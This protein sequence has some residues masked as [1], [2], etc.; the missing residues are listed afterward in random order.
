MTQTRAE[1]PITTRDA[2]RLSGLAGPERPERHRARIDDH[3]DSHHSPAQ[4]IGNRGLN[5]RHR[6]RIE[7]HGSEA[8]TKQA[9]CTRRRAWRTGPRLDGSQRGMSAAR[10]QGRSKDGHAGEREPLFAAH[11]AERGD[12]ERAHGRA[13]SAAGQEQAVAAHAGVN[14]PRGVGGDHGFIAHADHAEEGHE[15]ELGEEPAVVS[16]VAQAAQDDA[17]TERF[18]MMGAWSMDEPDREHGDDGGHEAHAVEREAA[19]CSEEREANAGERRAEHARGV[20]QPGVEGDC[21]RQDFG[22]DQLEEEDLAAGQLE[23]DADSRERQDR[24][25][26]ARCA[27]PENRPGRSGRRPAPSG[28]IP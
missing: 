13:D 15:R 2:P 11:S 16:K 23:G 10:G 17:D 14:D 27:R 20:E 28:R 9:E 1:R 19:G 3:P 7:E 25:P 18:A 22:A 8:G 5:H 21:V 4:L 26:S 24:A 6:R 12:D